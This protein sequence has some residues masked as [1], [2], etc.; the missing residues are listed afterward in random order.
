MQDNYKDVTI[1]GRTFRI[2]K[3]SAKVGAFM[4]LKV[5][6]LIAPLFKNVDLNK[7]MNV[8]GP[9]DIDLSTFNFA[10][11]MAE[12][13][14]LSEDDFN[15]I[16]DRC[17]QVCSESLP[18]GL[19]PVLNPNG[20]FGVLNLEDDTMT[21]LALT[22]HVLMFNL[23]SVFTGSPLASLLGGLSTTSLQG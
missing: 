16:Q 12:L 1:N 11:I 10:G 7:L 20:S 23:K 13:G 21:V 18:A 14:N 15:Y 8:K 5:T 9:E 19:T 17:L 3:F 22:V 4:V 6:G 2:R